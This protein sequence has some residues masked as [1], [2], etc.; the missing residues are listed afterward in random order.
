MPLPGC[1]CLAV[2]ALLLVLWVRPANAHV[3]LDLRDVDVRKVNACAAELRFKVKYRFP[4]GFHGHVGPAVPLTYRIVVNAFDSAAGG[5]ETTIWQMQVTDH[6]P[7]TTILWVVPDATRTAWDAQCNL[8]R[9]EEVVVRVD[10]QNEVPEANE[11]NNI[12]QKHWRTPS[13]SLG[14]CFASPPTPCQ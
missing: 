5:A 3:D 9:F 14:G 6:S 2:L 4:V 12:K 8:R 7:G 13:P 11:S 1:R 10:D